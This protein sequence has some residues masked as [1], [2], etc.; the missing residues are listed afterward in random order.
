MGA[1]VR[2]NQQAK[3]QAGIIPIRIGRKIRA[4]DRKAEERRK[5]IFLPVAAGTKPLAA[6]EI[7]EL[8]AKIRRVKREIAEGTR[9]AE[10][11]ELADVDLG[12]V[13]PEMLEVLS[14]AARLTMKHQRPR[15][16][17]PTEARHDAP[18]G[19]AT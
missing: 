3:M 15:V 16:F 9:P 8:F 18:G 19:D 5:A 17:R 6:V 4:K 11:I 10:P 2:R 14:D 12:P 1:E 7:E 13:G